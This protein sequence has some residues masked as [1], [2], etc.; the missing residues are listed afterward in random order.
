MK[1]LVETAAW[2]V[3]NPVVLHLKRRKRY[4]FDPRFA[5]INLG[6]GVWTPPNWLGL[7][8]GV[9]L[10]MRHLPNVAVNLLQRHNFFHNAANDNVVRYLRNPGALR[11]MH[12][13]TSYGLPFDAG[14]VPAVYSSHFFEHLT[15]DNGQALM[16]ECLRVLKPGGV[17]R[18]CLPDLASDVR[19]MKE[20]IAAYEAG[21]ATPMQAYVTF[22]Q[23]VGY[24]NPF[25]PHKYQYDFAQL[26]LALESAGFVD[27]RPCD[28]RE[29]RIADVEQLDRKPFV[30]F[31]AEAIKP[32]S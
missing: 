25:T 18:F 12:W 21:D 29:G 4:Q 16:K 15:W 14:V 32:A 10:L 2:N 6:C 5:G 20:A 31:H 17:I 26:R 13:D 9:Y 8:G 3:V 7:D 1:T 23:W 28:Y 19:E 30:S 24:T 11:I 22:G 27:V